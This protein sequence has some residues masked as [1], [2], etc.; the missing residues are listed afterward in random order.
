MSKLS[1]RLSNFFYFVKK[2]RQLFIFGTLI[3][4][5]I[6]FFIPMFAIVG[7]AWSGPDHT[8]KTYY[9]YTNTFS[10]LNAFNTQDT[11]FLWQFIA[12]SFGITQ[13]LTIICLITAFLITI[14]KQDFIHKN[15][16]GAYSLMTS[17]ISIIISFVLLVLSF[18][19][20]LDTS[21]SSQHAIIPH[22][23]FFIYLIL[24]VFSLLHFIHLNKKKVD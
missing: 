11:N 13:I 3:L 21:S 17:Y 2:H 7:F 15:H 18:L 14:I 4:I 8:D 5:I 20:T 12:I 16:I 9:T 1:T 24:A 19:Y 22:V 23:S 6:T 10:M